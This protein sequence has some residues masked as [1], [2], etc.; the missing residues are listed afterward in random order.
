MK[1]FSKFVIKEITAPAMVSLVTFTFVFLMATIARLAENLIE[2][3]YTLAETGLL[4]FYN[5]PAI[6]GYVI[7]M[8]LL[9]GIIVGLNRLSADSEVIAL[10]SSGVSSHSFLFPLLGIAV[11]AWLG[12]TWLLTEAVPWANEESGKIVLEHSREVISAEVKPHIFHEDFPG[13]II[14]VNDIDENDNRRW[15]Q[16]FIYDSS[17]NSYPKAIL[18]R[19][20]DLISRSSGGTLDLNMAVS[21]TYTFPRDEPGQPS[22]VSRAVNNT[23]HLME[24]ESLEERNANASDIRAKTVPELL[25]NID[26]EENYM[27][28]RASVRNGAGSPQNIHVSMTVAGEEVAADSLEVPQTT[29]GETLLEIPLRLTPGYERHPLKL[30]ISQGRRKLLEQD[31]T[32]SDFADRQYSYSVARH[33][34]GD[35]NL[36]LIN[37]KLIRQKT[38]AYWI[39]IHKK[40]SLPFTCIIFALLGLPLGLS[41]RRGGK[42]Y[43]Y[44]VGISIFIIYWGLHI[45]GERLAL[46]ER[47][48]PALGMWMPN[49]IFGL[50]AVLL[51]FLRRRAEL[52]VPGLGQFLL[53]IRTPEDETPET[54]EPGED[55]YKTKK[56]ARKSGRGV[57]EQIGRA[58]GFPLIVDRYLIKTFLTAFLLVF[59]IVYAVFSLVNFIDV[60]ND[61]QKNNVDQAILIDYFQFVAPETIR[62]VLPISTLMGTM[63]SF[64]LLSKNSEIIAFKSSGVSIYRLSVPVIFMALVVSIFAFYNNDFLI[65][66]TAPRLAEIKGIIRDRPI[67]TT[68][69]PRNRWVLGEEKNRIYHFQLYNEDERLLEELHVYDIDPVSY[70]LRQHIYARQAEWSDDSWVSDNGWITYFSGTT[71]SPTEITSVQ[72]LPIPEHPTYFGQEIKPSDQMSYSELTDYVD[73]LAAYGFA[74]TRENFDLYW[75]LSFPFLPLVMTLL[76]LPFAF[77]TARRSGPM[78]GISISIGLV[79]VYWGMMSLFRALGQTG[80]LPALLAA[81]APN[82]A[83]IGFGALLFATLRS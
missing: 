21:Y 8:A 72:E 83:F 5:L 49:F 4:L 24:E 64:A 29:G 61:I 6:L 1:I 46:Y 35:S 23:F 51:L 59:V 36:E 45:T 27:I 18:A 76:G 81:W 33:V 28:F 60:N 70:Q 75:K 80:L 12:N 43:G 57:E 69:D 66:A 62:W 54:A 77:T 25:E 37:S 3:Q 32:V 10:T 31:F 38:N 78:T 56:R 55:E 67:Q 44:V 22:A 16:V 9:L 14:Y 58:Y 7:P 19:H 79:I 63:I 39:E 17:D 42:A 71:R 74:T 65:P 26:R 34:R 68:R 11:F 13:F 2:Y 73:T 40:F 82:I 48:S 47:V 20:A 50:I 30:Q 53:R 41:S 15:K 52:R